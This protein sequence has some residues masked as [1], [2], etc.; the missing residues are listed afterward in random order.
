[1]IKRGERPKEMNLSI[2]F[3]VGVNPVFSNA[4]NANLSG[5]DFIFDFGFLD[6]LLIEH[7]WNSTSEGESVPAMVV[8]PTARV[9]LS[10]QGTKLLLQRLQFIMDQIEKGQQ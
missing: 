10:L 9:V 4:A 2:Q 8:E 6:P 1:M 3:A 5:T 7:V